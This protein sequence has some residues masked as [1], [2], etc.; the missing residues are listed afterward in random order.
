VAPIF[1]AQA[2][3]NATVSAANPGRRPAH[4]VKVHPAISLG[5]YCSFSMPFL[6]S[7]REREQAHLASSRQ[8]GRK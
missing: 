2:L 5:E 4:P 6:D 3:N 8:L 7:S 1:E